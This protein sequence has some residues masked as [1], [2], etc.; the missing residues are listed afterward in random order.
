MQN[1]LK[2]NATKDLYNV[3]IKIKMDLYKS[4]SGFYVHALEII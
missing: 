3:F 4:D 1:Y 2:N